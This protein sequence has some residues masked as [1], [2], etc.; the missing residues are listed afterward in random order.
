MYNTLVQSKIQ[1]VQADFSS[2]VEGLAKTVD[3]A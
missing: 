3:E 1:Q 2:K